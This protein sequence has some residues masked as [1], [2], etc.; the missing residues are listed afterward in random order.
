[1]AG[2]GHS[3]NTASDTAHIPASA[4]E[5]LESLPPTLPGAEIRAVNPPRPELHTQRTYG[6]N[7]WDFTV[8]P[9]VFL[10]GLTSRSVHDRILDGGIDVAG[11]TYVA[12]GAGLGVEA[13]IAGIRGARAVYAV[14]SH[15]E[16]V[17]AATAHY[18]RIVGERSRTAY[19]PVVSDLFDRFP[20]GVQADVVTFNPPAVAERTSD[21]PDAIRNVCVGPAIAT[22]FF[23]QIAER[24]LLAPSGEIF[25]IAS[26]TSDLRS[27]IAHAIAT[28]FAP[29]ILHIQTYAGDDVRT[30]LFRLT[31]GPRAAAGRRG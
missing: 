9:G 12:M 4:H 21:D 15:A 24:D 16:S 14:D 22:R 25:L 10:P 29:E 30:Y 13:V 1:M 2:T 26:N 28:G 7:G 20:D 6:Y 18:R 17:E 3:T 19:V 27:I 8:P 5:L 11:R 31:R 23:D